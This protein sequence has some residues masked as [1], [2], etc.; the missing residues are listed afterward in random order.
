MSSGSGSINRILGQLSSSFHIGERRISSDFLR[1][2]GLGVRESMKSEDIATFTSWSKALFDPGSEGIEDTI[3][4]SVT[5]RP[6][7]THAIDMSL[8]SDSSEDVA[9][10]S[11]K[12]IYPCNSSI[13]GMQ[14]G[15][16]GAKQRH[17][18]FPRSASWVDVGRCCQ[19]TSTR[20]TTPRVCIFHKPISKF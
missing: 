4:R 16:R 2:T 13:Q 14:D 15:Q 1:M 9:E 17:L 5:P 12:L 20:Y 6:Y 3:L 19:V 11:A 18:V 10:N 7:D 8:Q